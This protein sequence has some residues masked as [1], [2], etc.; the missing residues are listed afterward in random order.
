MIV[1][2]QPDTHAVDHCARWRCHT[3]ADSDRRRDGQCL[4]P[5]SDGQTAGDT[6]TPT[7]T[8]VGLEAAIHS[9]PQHVPPLRRAVNILLLPPAN[10]ATPR[11]SIIDTRRNELFCIIFNGNRAPRKRSGAAMDRLK[12]RRKPDRPH[13]K[14][15][16]PRPTAQPADVAWKRRDS[17]AT[18]TNLCTMKST[19]N[20]VKPITIGT[21]LIN[22]ITRLSRQLS[23]CAR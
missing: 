16:E 11:N 17:A 15:A 1:L 13:V 7:H 5:T 22:T 18:G 10:K 9:R 6:Q 14:R 23:R 19:T 21:N 8:C 4:Q 2:I 20:C 3:L 12:S